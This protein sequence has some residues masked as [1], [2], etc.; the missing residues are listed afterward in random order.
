MRGGV[1][2]YR[3][4]PAAARNYVEAGRCRADDY[5]LAEGTGL[6]QRLAVSRGDGAVREL[7]PLSGEGYERWVAGRDPNTG[8]S[9]GRVRDDAH[10]VRFVE[11]VVNGPKSWSLAAELHPEI[12]AAYEAAQD[13]AARQILG[14]LSQHATTRVGPRGGQVAVPVEYLEAAVVRHYTSRAGDPHR[15][16]HL[17]VNA[18]VFAAGKWRGLD[19]V[20]FRDSIQAVNGIGHAAVACDPQFRAALAGHGLTLDGEGEITQLAPFVGAFSKRAAQIR[21]LLDR[22]EAEWSAAHPGEEPGPV[23]RRSWN[24]RAWAENRPDKIVPRDGAELRQQW[25]GELHALGY[26]APRRPVQLAL[27]LAGAIDR[28]TVA[29]EVIARLGSA[30]SAWNAAD[31]R[32]QVELLLA[33]AGLVAEPAVRVELAEDLTARALALCVTLHDTGVPEHVRALTSPHVLDV[34]ADLVARLAA[35][36]A[37]PPAATPE[38]LAVDERLDEAQRTAVTALASA[39]PLV[40]VEGAAGAGKTTVL[41]A[42]RAALEAHGRRLV[43]V[44]PTLKAAQAASVQVGAAAG[45]AAWLAWQHGYRWDD[46]GT[47]TRVVHDPAPAAQLRAGDLLLIDEAGLLDQ[48]TARALLTI[49]DETGARVA[50]V[51]DRHQL[52]AVGRGGVLDLAHRFAHPEA[53]VDLHTVHRFLHLVDGRPVPDGDYA[54]LTVAMRTGDNP[55]AVFD[56]LAARGQVVLHGSDAERLAA[57]AELVAGQRSEGGAPLVVVDT[58]EQA[59]ALNAAVRDQLVTA[60]AVDD[61]RATITH[62]GQRLGVGDT[63][64]T[65]RNDPQLAVA[66]R[67]SWTVNRVYRDGGITVAGPHRGSRDLPPGYVAGHVELGYAVT[68]Y[69]AQGDTAEAAHLLM[70]EGT[71]AASV[72][73]GMTRG[74]W[75]NTAHL[76]ADDLDD[77]REQWISAAGRDRADLGPAAASHAAARAAGGYAPVRP[78]PAVLA[79]LHTLWGE[80]DNR[81]R[82]L[83]RALAL[84]EELQQAVELC[85]ERDRVLPQ[86]QATYEQTRATAERARAA[87]DW[88]RTGIEQDTAIACDRLLT[89]WDTQREQARHAAET[90]RRGPGRLGLRLVAVNRATETLA[91]WSVSWQPYLPDMPT[92]SRR[93]AHYATWRH[94]RQ[95]LLAA[96][97]RHARPHAEQAHPDHDAL[98]QAA[99]QA[100]HERQQARRTLHNTDRWFGNQLYRHARSG[101][102]ADP[103]QRLADLD[104]RI[105]AQQRR[106]DVLDERLQRLTHEPAVT[107][108]PDPD[109]WL[110]DQHATW[111]R[112]RDEQRDEQQRQRRAAQ[113]RDELDRLRQPAWNPAP[114]IHRGP[115]I[116]R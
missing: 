15:H 71:T 33:R 113:Q 91:T 69:G 60:D 42:T 75:A 26:R 65:R 55:G 99:E 97:D 94:D 57:L 81:R 11:V 34:Q 49:A 110:T 32:G 21:G 96:F 115:S 25:L 10:G 80:Q 77:A 108:R 3:G 66:N 85:A 16:L 82:E 19:T 36:G 51:G 2:V 22:Y 6:A 46:T 44:T 31:V 7:A 47:W 30:R 95:Q 98:Q 100:E 24:G 84:R 89:E 53:V 50:L 17:Q 41:A 70:G 29:V 40:V 62:A 38:R 90:V 67:D 104:T 23:L 92:D 63:V 4:A 35:R 93:I 79:D 12:A 109:R 86:L 48:D 105:T 1:K 5:Y 61:T 59:A 37:H 107:S 58:R 56:R 64:V 116:G 111:K 8:E 28:D 78:L 106:L 112:H 52:P 73:V 13:N 54:D 39:A 103:A 18:R 87:A 102:L 9:R 27:P 83:D 68:G 72:Y 20:A 43:V 76:V 114:A 101:P 88:A 45:S 14:W 74:R